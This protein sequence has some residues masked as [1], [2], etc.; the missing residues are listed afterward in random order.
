MAWLFVIPKGA[1]K[2]RLA[3]GAASINEI[4][5]EAE[6]L[7]EYFINIGEVTKKADPRY[8][9]DWAE[10]MGYELSPWESSTLLRMFAAYEAQLSKSFDPKCPD[11]RLSPE[12]VNKLAQKQITEAIAHHGRHGDPHSKGGCPRPQK[13]GVRTR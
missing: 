1:V 2:T 4:S 8:I 10:M 5:V 9:M 12:E 13:N 7:L 11:P 6:Y 3:W